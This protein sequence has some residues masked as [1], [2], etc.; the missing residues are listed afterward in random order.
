MSGTAGKNSSIDLEVMQECWPLLKRE[1]N[2]SSWGLTWVA[3]SA[4][5]AAWSYSIGGYVGYYLNAGM[6]T[7]AMLAGCLVGMF[8]VVLAAVPSS[9]KYGI[10]SIATSI[11]Q[12]GTRGSV[13][14]IF[15]QYASIIGWNCLLLILFGRAL[16]EVLVTTKMIGAA[17]QG[18]VSVMATL[19]AISKAP[20]L[21]LSQTPLSC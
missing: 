15:L 7:A 3:L 13:F 19:A 20:K 16:G 12:F 9:A 17:S 18:F 5:V 1:R 21:D 2:W 14:A 6:G 4:G 10:E 11:P 8:L